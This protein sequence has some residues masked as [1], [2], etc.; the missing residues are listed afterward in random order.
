MPTRVAN[1]VQALHDCG[2]AAQSHQHASLHPTRRVLVLEESPASVNG[3]LGHESALTIV[4]CVERGSG[5]LDGHAPGKGEVW[6]GYVNCHEARMTRSAPPSPTMQRPQPIPPLL[7]SAWLCSCTAPLGSDAEDGTA[8]R[9]SSSR[10]HWKLASSLDGRTR[11][12][13]VDKSSFSGLHSNQHGLHQ[14]EPA[15]ALGKSPT[16]P[17]DLARD[18]V[19]AVRVMGN[20]ARSTD[21]CRISASVVRMRNVLR[22]PAREE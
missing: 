20:P 18:C 16:P 14:P 15:H 22:S 3:Q 21:A 1:R 5:T 13:C 19:S 11:M 9:V 4:C 7:G 8:T 10:P 12:S 17:A 6:H 2:S